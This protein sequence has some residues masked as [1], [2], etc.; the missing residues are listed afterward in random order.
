MRD[1]SSELRTTPAWIGAGWRQ[2]SEIEA[3]PQRIEH[4]WP[5]PEAAVR[6][7]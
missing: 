4:E 6:R 2:P 3:E 1:M 7:R 5:K